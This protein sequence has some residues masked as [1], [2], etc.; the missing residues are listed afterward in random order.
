M[1]LVCLCSYADQPAEPLTPR[2]P[3]LKARSKQNHGSARISASHIDKNAHTSA[4]VAAIR[5]FGSLA[6][7]GYASAA[8]FL[9]R[10]TVQIPF[11]RVST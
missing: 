6:L 2:V 9:F 8:R 5:T 1:I 3:Q 4:S 10:K 11:I 7:P